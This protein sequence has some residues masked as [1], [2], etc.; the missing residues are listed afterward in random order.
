MEAALASLHASLEQLTLANETSAALNV[1]VAKLLAE[2]EALVCMT[3]HLAAI[4]PDGLD[5]L[6][7]LEPVNRY[8]N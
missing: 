6:R 5:Y 1:L 2:K 4:E 3:Q 8:V 7:A